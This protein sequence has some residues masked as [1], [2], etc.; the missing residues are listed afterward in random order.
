MGFETYTKLYHSGVVPVMDYS[1][2]KPKLRTYITFKDNYCTEKYFKECLPR[3]EK[4]LLTPIRFG[5]L[6]LHIETGHF[7]SLDLEERIYKVCNSQEIEE[8]FQFIISCNAYIEIQQ[9]MHN[10]I[11]YIEN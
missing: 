1:S 4:S 5:I 11:T 10:C 6:P 9:V 7:R 8:E 3:K 2:I